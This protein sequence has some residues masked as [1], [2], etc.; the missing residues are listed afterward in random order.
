MVKPYGRA[1][2]K[3]HANIGNGFQRNLVWTNS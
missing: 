1:S 2:A 3:L